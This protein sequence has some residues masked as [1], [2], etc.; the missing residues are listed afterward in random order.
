M[1]LRKRLHNELVELK[2]N[3]RVYCRVRPVIKEDGAGKAAESVVTF[4]EDDDG[5]LNVFSK[6][7]NKPFEMDKV[8][9]PESTQEQ[10][11]YENQV[12]CSPSFAFC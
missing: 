2:G 6:G 8:F 12:C 10:V 5:I 9:T 3:I 4:D 1:T 7:T 11:S